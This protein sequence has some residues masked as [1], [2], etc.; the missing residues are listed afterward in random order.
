MEETMMGPGPFYQCDECLLLFPE[1]YTCVAHMTQ[2]HPEKIR[3]ARP[4]QREVQHKEEPEKSTH[5]II[6]NSHYS[7][8]TSKDSDVSCSNKNSHGSNN[9][10]SSNQITGNDNSDVNGS[11]SNQANNIDNRCD[12]ISSNSSNV[13]NSNNTSDSNNQRSNVHNSSNIHSIIRDPKTKLYKCKKCYQTFED[14]CTYLIHLKTHK[15]EKK[16]NHCNRCGKAFRY[17]YKPL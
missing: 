11:I 2:H 1:L 16:P 3:K 12:I 17:V 4:K 8:Q 13:N 10:S 7:N 6:N 9:V 14:F 15:K 5:G